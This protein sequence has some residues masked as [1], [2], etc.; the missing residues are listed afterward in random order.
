MAYLYSQLRRKC[1]GYIASA[2]RVL[3]YQNLQYF[4]PFDIYFC[5][6]SLNELGEFSHIKHLMFFCTP[7]PMVSC[8]LTVSI[9]MIE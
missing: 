3:N 1:R 9:Q 7:N 8:I 2:K 5:G 4:F 6:K